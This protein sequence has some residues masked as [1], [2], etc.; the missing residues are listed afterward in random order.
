MSSVLGRGAGMTGGTENGQP[1]GSVHCDLDRQFKLST[2]TDAE[3]AAWAS[4]AKKNR[5]IVNS[6]SLNR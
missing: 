4:T 1:T 5:L 3:S 2:D 6:Q